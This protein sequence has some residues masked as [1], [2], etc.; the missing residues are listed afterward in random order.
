MCKQLPGVIS[1]KVYADKYGMLERTVRKQLFQGYC[2]WP[3]PENT[4]DTRGWGDRKSHKWY[5]KW[6]SIK[7]RCT[8]TYS[9]SYKDY[10]ARGIKMCDQWSNN[11]WSF[12]EYLDTLEIPVNTTEHLSLDRID[13]NGNYEPGNVRWAT[14][15][16][17]AQNKRTK[18]TRSKQ[19]LSE[20]LPQGMTVAWTVKLN[21]WGV[22]YCKSFN[23]RPDADKYLKELLNLKEVQN[24]KSAA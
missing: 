23:N 8:K 14:N 20:D 2:E 4:R 1:I 7:Q 22:R 21:I 15:L 16:Q 24:E 18:P 3:R 19:G 10:G 5:Y 6:Q 9:K 13:P 12:V 11:F 17:Q